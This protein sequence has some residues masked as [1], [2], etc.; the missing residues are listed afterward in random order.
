MTVKAALRIL[1]SRK[2]VISA[3]LTGFLAG[4][5]TAG[6]VED[7]YAG[8]FKDELSRYSGGEWAV[9]IDGESIG[10]NY[11]DER[12]WLYARY[13]APREE[14]DDP[15]FRDRLLRKLIDNYIVLREAQ[16][17][18][19]FS[20]ENARRYLWLYIEEAAAAYYLDA[21]A[22]L[23]N[24]PSRMTE[25]EIGE[26]YLKNEQIFTRRNIT[27]EKALGMIRSGL[28]DIARRLPSPDRITSRRVE[29]GRLKKGKSI[30]INHSQAQSAPGAPNKKSER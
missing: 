11:I 18:R 17:A 26:F 23:R 10:S 2:M 12:A 29:L 5:L 7:P 20:N 28:D 1:S 14:P 27:R 15:L 8:L 9:R 13:I 6:I 16:K 30:V 25:R 19:L 21:M 22:G 24:T 3:G 4:F